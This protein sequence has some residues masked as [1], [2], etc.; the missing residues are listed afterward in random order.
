MTLFDQLGGA[1]KLRSILSSFYDRL[2]D[3][4]MIGY[5]FHG[6]PKERLIELEYQFT[7]R[8]LGHKIPYEGRGMRAAHG[9]HRIMGG[10][11]ERRFV[12]LRETL[13]SHAVPAAVQAEWLGH[14]R[15]LKASVVHNWR[16]PTDASPSRGQVTEH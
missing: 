6:L 10:Q 9:R 5:M 14:T 8:L 12:V 15:A 1:D 3:D 2:Y 7:A 11:F 16:E 13:E 4:I